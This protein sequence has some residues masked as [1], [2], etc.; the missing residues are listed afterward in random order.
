MRNRFAEVF[1]SLAEGDE[2]LA[3]IV[4]DISPAGAM[5]KFRT[6]FPDRFINTG[7]AEQIMIGMA[8]GMAMQGMRPFAYTIATFALF[9][10]YEFIRDDVCYQNLPVTVVGIGGGVT[11]STLGATHHALEDINIATGLP[12]M[13]VFSPCDPYEVEVLTRWCATKNEGPVYMRLGKAG[14]SLLGD[15]TSDS[16]SVGRVR[17]LRKGGKVCIIGHGP[18]LSLATRL[19]DELR[20]DGSEIAVASVHSLKPID[21]EGLSTI[22]KS[23][24][25]VI[26]LEECLPKGALTD[27]L[28]ALSFDI[29][30]R[31]RIHSFTLKDEF[32][33]CYGT[34]EQLLEAHG[35]SYGLI[36]ELAQSLSV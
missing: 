3:A 14:E 12:N 20:S 4:A 29:G 15:D 6:R 22:L 2:K 8:A 33:H 28:K 11:Y 16:L 7:V 35:I 18:I 34:H 9:R 17:Y 5:D 31:P 30:A 25:N 27:C 26:V 10:P 23:F 19:S 13:R 36:R 1:Y 21:F 24:E 32:I